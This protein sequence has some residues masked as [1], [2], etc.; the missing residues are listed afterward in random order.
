MEV[1]AK[2]APIPLNIPSKSYFVNPTPLGSV[3]SSIPTNPMPIASQALR[4]NFSFKKI[5]A[6]IAVNIGEVFENVIAS[7]SGMFAML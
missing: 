1:Y 6:N 3:M 7:P 2:A 5:Q 4:D